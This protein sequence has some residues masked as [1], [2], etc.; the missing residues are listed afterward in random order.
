MDLRWPNRHPGH[1]QRSWRCIWGTSRGFLGATIV[2]FA[3]VVSS[4]LIVWTIWYAYVRFGGLPWMQA[5]FYGVGAA[6]IGIIARSVQKLIPLTL[7]PGR[8][9]WAVSWRWQQSRRTPSAR[10]PRCSC[11]RVC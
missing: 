4:F 1:S 3:F 2:S 6:V 9:T 8:V 11:S 7:S 5:I 10:S